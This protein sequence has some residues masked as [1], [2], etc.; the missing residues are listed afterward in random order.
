MLAMILVLP[1]WNSSE[2][3][4][5][6]INDNDVYFD[7][8][9]SS[10]LDIKGEPYEINKNI[11]DTPFDEYVYMEKIDS[12]EASFSYVMNKSRLIEVSVYIENIDYDSALEI[13][14]NILNKQERHYSGF[15]GY[16]RSDLETDESSEFTV[17]GGVISG[18]TGLSFDYTYMSG[19]LII[20]AVCQK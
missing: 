1:N 2:K 18:A 14:E 17:S 6:F 12:Y 19:D 16:Y 11:G 13:S 3:Q 7:M 10:L 20:T 9:K 8:R 15:S 4:Y 5:L